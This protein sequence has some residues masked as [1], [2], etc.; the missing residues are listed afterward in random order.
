MAEHSIAAARASV[1]LYDDQQKK[2]IPSGSS[3]GLSKVHVYH[4]S[5]NNT[6][7]W[8]YWMTFNPW[9][10]LGVCGFPFFIPLLSIPY[11]PRLPFSVVGRKIQD[12]E[13]VINCAILKGLKYNQATATFHQWRDNRQVGSTR[14]HPAFVVTNNVSNWL[15]NPLPTTVEK[16]VVI[17]ALSVEIRR[18]CYM[19][20]PIVRLPLIYMA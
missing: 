17:D 10:T 11:F 18:R 9:F 2:W 15:F 3:Q 1:M 13:V 12:H 14:L 8:E 7:R 16:E 20:F 4:H 6:F 19:R 5:V